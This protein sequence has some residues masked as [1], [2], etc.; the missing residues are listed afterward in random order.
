L[1]EKKDLN[2]AIAIPIQTVLTKQ[3]TKKVNKEKDEQDYV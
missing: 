3:K 1:Q 2:L